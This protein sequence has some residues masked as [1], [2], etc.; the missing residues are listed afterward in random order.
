MS[1]AENEGAAQNRNRKAGPHQSAPYPVF[2]EIQE[3]IKLPVKLGRKSFPRGSV[4]RSCWFN[5]VFILLFVTR[6]FVSGV[7]R[8]FEKSSNRTAESLSSRPQ[9]K[10]TRRHE[11]KS[12]CRKEELC[13]TIKEDDGEK[14]NYANQGCSQYR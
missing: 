6:A 10:P 14:I 11:R 9:R 3:P 5:L 8:R 7:R 2:V 13:D 1:Q 4:G 12:Q